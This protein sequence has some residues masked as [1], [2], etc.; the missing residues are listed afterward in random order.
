MY[1]FEKNII[2]ISATPAAFRLSEVFQSKMHV[3]MCCVLKMFTWA[4][5]VIN[6]GYVFYIS[7]IIYRLNCLNNLGKMD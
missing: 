4:V 5:Y 1:F 6:L 2:Y 7:S 3:V